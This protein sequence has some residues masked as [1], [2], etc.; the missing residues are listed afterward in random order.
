[1][2][3]AINIDHELLQRWQIQAE[4]EGK[5]IVVGGIIFN[6]KGQ[7]FIQKR[8]AHK[9]LFP[10][11]WDLSAGGRL[12][13]GESVWQ[14]LDREIQEETG[15]KLRNIVAEV[16]VFDWETE[17]EG[18]LVKYREMDFLVEV[19]G[20]LS[21][22]RIEAENFSEARWIS[23]HEI[24]ILNENKQDIVEEDT[25]FRLVNKAFQIYDNFNN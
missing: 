7:V 8:A 16:D 24:N 1:M 19:E 6:S 12:E 21:Q 5:K 20:D 10:N 13:E 25:I 23:R 4:A 14:A 17:K 9:K 22:P 3:D 2:T 18:Q 11:C 15:W